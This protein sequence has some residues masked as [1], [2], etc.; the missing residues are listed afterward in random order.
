M[1]LRLRRL[2]RTWLAASAHPLVGVV[3]LHARACRGRQGEK[4]RRCRIW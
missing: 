3:V 1:L 4:G 2:A